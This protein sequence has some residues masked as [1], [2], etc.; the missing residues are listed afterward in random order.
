MIKKISDVVLEKKTYRQFIKFVIVGLI[1][2][3]I[4]WSFFYLFKIILISRAGSVD[5]QILRQIAKALSFVVS[6]T[7]GYVMSRRWTFRSQDKMIAKQATKFAVVSISGMVVN[8]C[9][10]YLFTNSLQM[11]DIVGLFAAGVVAML[12]NFFINKKWTFRA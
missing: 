4:D 3:A 9:I 10:F 12:S 8:Q 2:T 5:L 6:A 11:R 1:S 7:F